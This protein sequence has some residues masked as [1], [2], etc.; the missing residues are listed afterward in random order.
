MCYGLIMAF[1]DEL[2][3]WYVEEARKFQ[4]IPFVR[5]AFAGGL[6]RPEYVH[7]LKDYYHFVRSAGPVYSACAA[8][9]DYRFARVRDWFA[10][11]AFKEIDH[12]RFVVSDLKAL[13]IPEA[14]TR[15]SRPGTA[16]DALCCYNF[17]FIEQHHPVGLLGTPFLMGKLSAV[18][19]LHASQKIKEA[20]NLKEG[21]AS[22][23]EAHGHLDREQPEDVGLVI[24][25]IAETD[26]QAE[27]FLNAKTLF[28][29]Y[30]GFLRSLSD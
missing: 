9:I 28:A 5:R 20:L 3:G 1:W 12:D 19:S 25:S 4:E 23:F 13:G 22:F 10:K 17:G 16:M 30:V 24:Q 15:Q 21:G 26:M 29:L 2:N 11:C 14:E 8:K 27:I 7:F 6:T 18:Y